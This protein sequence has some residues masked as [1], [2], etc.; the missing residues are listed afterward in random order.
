MQKEITYNQHARRRWTDV[1]SAANC[2]QNGEK[3]QALVQGLV[4]DLQSHLDQHMPI[5]KRG[6]MQGAHPLTLS[7]SLGVGCRSR[8][9]WRNKVHRHLSDTQQAVLAHYA[10]TP[11]RCLFPT[12]AHLT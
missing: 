5:S 4:R 10:S 12:Q 2:P 1:C 11:P 3:S 6:S 9:E 7:P 8:R